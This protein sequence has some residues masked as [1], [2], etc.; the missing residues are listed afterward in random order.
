MFSITVSFGGYIGADEIYEVY[1]D[2]E[3]EA[4]DEAL[5]D[6][7]ENLEVEDVVE[8]ARDTWEVTIG[9]AGMI[10]V[11]ETYEVEASNEEDACDAALEM[12]RDDLEVTDISEEADD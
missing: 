8:T 9:F 4:I 6:A 12:A 5:D 1:A 7:F 3:D 11:E 2:S 10:G